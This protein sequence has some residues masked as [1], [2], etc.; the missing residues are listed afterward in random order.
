MNADE[1]LCP[2]CAEVVKVAARKCRFCGYEFA[3]A[4]LPA[5]VLSATSLS[6]SPA[7]PLAAPRLRSGDIVD[8]LTHLVD[9]NLAVYEED[10][11]GQGRNRLLETVRQYARDRLMES[12]EGEARRRRHLDYFVALADEA[13]PKLHGPEQV[14]WLNQLET[15]HDNW[16]VALDWCQDNPDTADRALHL[17]VALSPFWEL[18]G[19]RS[20]GIDRLEE[21]L[22]AQKPAQAGDAAKR[23]LRAKGL[24]AAGYL[25]ALFMFSQRGDYERARP[26]LE[27]S[28]RLAQELGEPRAIAT[29]LCRWGMLIWWR[30][31]FAPARTFLEQS[32]ALFQEI[33]DEYGISTALY[34]L[35]YNS[36]YQG[37][38]ATARR[39]FEQGLALDRKRGDTHAIG[40]SLEGLAYVS[41]EQQDFETARPLFEESVRLLR[42]IGNQAG[43]GNALMSLANVA[44]VQGDYKE[45]VLLLEESIALF[46][47]A[48]RPGS[49]AWALLGLGNVMRLLGDFGRAS[50]LYREGLQK[51][52]EVGD[53]GSLTVFMLERMAALAVAA[54]PGGLT[55]PRRAARLLGFSHSLRMEAAHP[56]PFVD[57]A[58]YYDRLVEDV[59]SALGAEAFA[60]FWA[61]GEAMTLEQATAYAMQEDAP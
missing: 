27:E 9:K 17:A 1:K 47:E 46:G 57:H 61:K 20:E 16:R 36:Y 45:A 44:R 4:S 56:L 33:G 38:R 37:D 48:G 51:L 23:M 41:W 11:Y 24:G 28:L 22:A 21:A 10:E 6:A 13:E 14:A 54:C 49:S 52:Q 25:L 31:G 59:Q 3:P 30:D 42:Q 34:R 12:G 43:I 8:L 29:A 60:A 58:D 15:E 32:L 50:A 2:D 55:G 7:T 19:P 5:N 26:L 53:T 40:A 18:R 35:A 39:L